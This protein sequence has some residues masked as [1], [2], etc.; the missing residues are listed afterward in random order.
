M[1]FFHTLVFAFIF[2]PN[3]ITETSRTIRECAAKLS[4]NSYAKNNT[5]TFSGAKSVIAMVRELAVLTEIRR[6]KSDLSKQTAHLDKIAKDKPEPLSEEVS[7][8]TQLG[9]Y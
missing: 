4:H 8:S 7:L 5:G 2:T 6:K 9:N 1:L 3:N